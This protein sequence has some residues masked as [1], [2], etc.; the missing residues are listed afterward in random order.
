MAVS[1]NVGGMHGGLELIF[2]ND[3]DMLSP[4]VDYDEAAAASNSNR[5]SPPIPIS[6]PRVAIA[7]IE[8]V[9]GEDFNEEE[10][11]SGLNYD[12][13]YRRTKMSFSTSDSSINT[14]VSSIMTPSN[15]VIASQFTTL[16]RLTS[17]ASDH[18]L[19]TT[20]TEVIAKEI[21]AVR[22]Y[23]NEAQELVTSLTKGLN[24][25][26]T[27]LEVLEQNVHTTRSTTTTT[28]PHAKSVPLSVK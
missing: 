14:S 10:E 26:L 25:M 20:N 28:R 21:E 11:D 6:T 1:H 17:S 3:E 12:E 13:V 7:G 27:R 19:K 5:T 24:V 22:L 16:A 2:S 4:F 8:N 23:I 18:A 9:D 15:G